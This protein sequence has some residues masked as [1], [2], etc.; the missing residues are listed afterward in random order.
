MKK[1]ANLRVFP[2]ILAGMIVGISFI[3]LTDLWI[4]AAVCAIALPSA[5]AFSVAAYKKSRATFRAA[6]VGVVCFVVGTV[7]GISSALYA[8]ARIESREIFAKDVQI[9]ARI[10]VGSSSDLSG[11]VDSCLIILDDLV[12]DGEEVGGR[13]KLYSLQ[14]PEG[15]FKEGDVIT[16]VGT[17]VTLTTDITTP[18]KA[19]ALAEGVLY[20][21]TA[22]D[23]EDSGWITVEGN[24]LDFFDKIK[25]AVAAKLAENASDGAARFMYA[26]LFGDSAVI[27]DDVRS[28][29]SVTGTAHLLAV[30]GLHVG[31]L[32]GALFFILKK[33]RINAVIRSVTVMAALIFFCAL[34]G[35]SPSTVRATVM[36][37]VS[38]AAA[39]C[40]LRYDPLSGMSLSAI[41]L[42]FVSPYNLYSLGFLMSFL[43]VYGL[44]LFAKP[45]N[46]VFLKARLPK[47]LA[48]A[49]SATLAANATLLPVM[50]YVFGETSLI[51][52]VANCIIVPFAG[53]FFPL[54]I[55]LLPLSFLPYAGFLTAAAS[56]PFLLTSA[57]IEWLAGI[58]FPTVYIELGWATIMLWLIVATAVSGIC[59][60]PAIAKKIIASVSVICIIAVILLQ[61]VNMLSFEN[62]VTC[63][64]GYGCSGVVVQSADE[65]DYIVFSGEL[66]ESAAQAA[67]QAMNKSKLRKVDFIVKFG[68]ELS[69]SEIL[70]EYAELFGT[71]TL[72]AEY[73]ETLGYDV[74]N[75]T[76][77]TLVCSVICTY[78]YTAIYLGGV[79]VLVSAVTDYRA[80]AA[81]YDVVVCAALTDLPE[82][83]EYLISTEAYLAGGNNCLPSD[84]TFWTVGDR[85]IKTNKWRFA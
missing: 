78:T 13:A 11:E 68:A 26:M 38:M 71:R 51:F 79:D 22:N 5:I 53:F 52:A 44:I 19:S 80:D 8:N 58:S 7:F 36:I 12:I 41:L 55:V 4:P 60:M 31:M 15:G 54:Y 85:I 25:K 77:L 34:C 59:A 27:G 67:V 62:K 16:F 42:L 61:N 43:A 83:P 1:I 10:E 29:F 9:T 37:G 65:G 18:Y 23:D 75:T 21:I 73:S 33:L 81:E 72:Y 40:G 84:F 14:L 47:W 70:D 32:A 24:S 50:I 69:E 28:D 64:S 48:G 76:E 45:L 2:T 3:I 35:F 20:E 56:V 82:G 39:L 74:H 6:V 49:L 63:F 66:D 46:G 17:V 57:V 30:S